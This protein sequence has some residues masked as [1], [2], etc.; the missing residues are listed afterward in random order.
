MTFK[1]YKVPRYGENKIYGHVKDIPYTGTGIYKIPLNSIC[2]N[3]KQEY[4]EHY[5]DGFGVRDA[6]CPK[7]KK[8]A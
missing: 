2:K 6:E 1:E 3:C 4:G 8:V 7:K 5:D